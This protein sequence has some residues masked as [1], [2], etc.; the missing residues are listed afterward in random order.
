MLEGKHAAVMTIAES[1][2]TA[3]HRRDHAHL[4]DETCCSPHRVEVI[5][6][7]LRAAMVCHDCRSD[8]GFVD[9]RAADQLAR[10]HRQH[11]ADAGGPTAA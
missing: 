6:L 8:S 10:S 4:A 9:A 2:L 7:G 3:A 1:T 5:R 11:T